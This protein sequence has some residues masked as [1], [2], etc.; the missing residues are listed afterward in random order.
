MIG[1]ALSCVS[2]SSGK[3]KLDLIPVHGKV[4]I[5]DKPAAGVL[6]TFLPASEGDTTSP[7]PFAKSSE[8]GTFEVLTNDEEGAPAGDYV[9]TAVLM[10]DAPAA[11]AKKGEAISMSMARDPVDKLGGKYN[12]R[13]KGIKVKVEKGVTELAPIKLN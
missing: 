8:D 3:P 11:D 13:A 12:A 10:Q 6:L 4:L 7:R 2:C 9:V 1:L 5:K